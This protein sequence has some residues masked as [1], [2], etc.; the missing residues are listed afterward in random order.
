MVKDN[1]IVEKWMMNAT[2]N[3]QNFSGDL[4]KTPLIQFYN[5]GRAPDK[6]S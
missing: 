2:I 1:T 4:K 3:L 6:N 5:Y